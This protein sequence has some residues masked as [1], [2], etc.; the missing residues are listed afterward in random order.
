MHQNPVPAR[1]PIHVPLIKVSVDGLAGVM[2]GNAAG[3]VLYTPALLPGPVG[4]FN[5]FH[6]KEQGIESSEFQE[7]GTV[8]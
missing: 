7:L 3:F 2:I 1:K 4:Y 8:V 6:Q 5:V